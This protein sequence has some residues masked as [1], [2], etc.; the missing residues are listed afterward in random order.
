MRCERCGRCCKGT[1]MEL[2]EEDVRR[3]ISLG[4][5]RDEFCS[6]GEDGVL[7]LRNIGGRCFFLSE[8]ERSCTIYEARP[9][10]CDIYPVNCDQEGRIFVDGFCRASGTVTKGELNKKGMALR[11]HLRT[12]DAE[13]RGRSSS[14]G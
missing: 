8:D 9:L 7:R 13:A 12:I 1:R 11:R 5:G 14:K 10:G 6:Q 2:S 3:L 4:H